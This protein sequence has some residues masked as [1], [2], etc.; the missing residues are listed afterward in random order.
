MFVIHYVANRESNQPVSKE[1][2]DAARIADA[3]ARGRQV[4]RDASIAFPHPEPG[5]PNP[6]GFLIYDATGATVLHREYMD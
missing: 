2:S 5:R 6:I 3:I 1:T 4:V